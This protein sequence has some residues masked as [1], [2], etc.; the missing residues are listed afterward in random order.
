MLAVQVQTHP[1]RIDGDVAVKRTYAPAAVAGKSVQDLVAA[2]QPVLPASAGKTGILRET[3]DVRSR[4]GRRITVAMGEIIPEGG[5]HPALI[6]RRKGRLVF[7]MKGRKLPGVSRITVH[8]H[9]LASTPPPATGALTV[10]VGGRSK[11][12]THRRLA[13][14]PL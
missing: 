1:V 7:L 4:S 2:A 3:L 10:N 6:K 8:V 11:V 14:L 12:L 9:N 13:H 5:N